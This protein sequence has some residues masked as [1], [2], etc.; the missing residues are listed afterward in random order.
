MA[1]FYPVD[2]PTL[3]IN[4]SHSFNFT[5]LNALPKEL[6]LALPR[7]ISRAGAFAFYN[8]PE[9]VDNLFGLRH[10]GSMIAEATTQ[11]SSQAAS[12]IRANASATFNRTL[13]GAE[14]TSI[15][16]NFAKHGMIG[17]WAWKVQIFRSLFA[18]LTSKWA[19]LCFSLALILN[20]TSVYASSRR[21]IQLPFLLRLALR[22]IPIL[23]FASH[24]ASLL[25]AI[26]CQTSPSF[27]STHPQ[28]KNITY[29]G[30]GGLIYKL[31]S[32]LLFFEE[33]Q[34]SCR[35]VGMSSLQDD[36]TSMR[37]SFSL[38]WPFFKSLCIGH[39]VETLSCTVQGRPVM[40]ETGLSIFEHSLAFA[41]AE[42]MLSE[43]LSFARLTL[44]SLLFGTRIDQPTSPSEQVDKSAMLSMMHTTPE[45]LL[46][47]LI[48]CLNSL[49]SHI[50]AVFD[51]QGR[52]RLI[53][54][55]FWG[56]CFMASI[57][58][59][60]T[61]LARSPDDISLI[62]FPTVCFV[63][64]I[65]HLLLLVGILACSAIY[66]TAFILTVL[67]PPTADLASR[68]FS[69]RVVKA[70]EN[71]QM[72]TQLFS[73][74]FNMRE[75]FYTA[76]MKFGFSVL[77]GASEAVYLNETDSV[78]VRPGTWAEEEQINNFEK[79]RARVGDFFAED[80]VTGLS[81]V[82]YT[83]RGR[84][85]RSGYDIE[86][87]NIA[88]VDRYGDLD[89]RISGEGVGMKQ[90]SGRTIMTVH[91]YTA[92]FWL[93]WRWLGVL[94]DRIFEFIGFE[95]AH[96]CLKS[97]RRG[98]VPVKKPQAVAHTGKSSSSIDLE[99][100][101]VENDM[102]ERLQMGGSL[103]D[104]NEQ[105]RLDN[106]LYSMWKVGPWWGERDESG[107]Y[108][109]PSVQEDDN[110]S[111]ISTTTAAS[112]AG[113]WESS[114]DADDDGTRT[115]T[116]L[117]PDLQSRSLS[118]EPLSDH[119]LDPVQLASLLNPQSAEQRHEARM[120]AHHLTSDHIITRS[121]YRNIETL[122][123][124]KVLSTALRAPRKLRP[125]EEVEALERLILSRRAFAK[126]MRHR[127][128][129]GMPAQTQDQDGFSW[130]HGA[131]G[132]GSDGPRCVV[133]QSEP[134]TILSWPCRCLSICE[135]CRISLAR[136]NFGTCVCC[137][138]DVVAF[139]RLFVP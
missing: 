13:A 52:F 30:N 7:L 108:T 85:W 33:E 63:G 118:P 99:E 114:S 41:E 75:D 131:A 100:I 112:D 115:P 31:T 113:D 61:N 2:D 66:F 109:A 96:G 119:A 135:D 25:Q 26:R 84:S 107:T 121:Q 37:G 91:F 127:S 6:V 23:L 136:T 68:P 124:T 72:H 40:T 50:L 116:Q 90:R 123:G 101:D 70:H 93:W 88:K 126:A 77:T 20:R 92:L 9:S 102:K 17:Y 103:W 81:A 139:S 80:G 110:T 11:R 32:A 98:S 36:T 137:R 27:S 54:T 106:K 67:S 65:P 45:V 73:I 56:L 105:Q 86:R 138:R 10:G 1:F 19:I 97:K 46:I 29:T 28:Q 89:T 76:L 39:F 43:R 48:S 132:L 44:S 42:A 53:N 18:Y 87:K 129:L 62:R 22:S 55:G 4:V 128:Q 15:P 134:R 117:R 64:F 34:V 57:G 79:A 12:A 14:A 8:V 120:L 83:F 51:K 95:H 5:S 71:L 24:A 47:A 133:C 69:E 58:W 125:D 49:T 94:I 38:L 3:P 104:D 74:P 35:A 122:Q 60:F 78:T 21:R 111:I 59:A 16:A 130:A 82:P